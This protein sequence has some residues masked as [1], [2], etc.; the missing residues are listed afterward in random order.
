VLDKKLNI[1][2]SRM[3]WIKHEVR[4]LLLIAVWLGFCYLRG[5][6]S[7]IEETQTDTPERS[8]S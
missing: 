8:S 2:R 7:P 4:A 1:N 5:S 6:S 3:V